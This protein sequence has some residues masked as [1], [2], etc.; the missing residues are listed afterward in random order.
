MCL[1]EEI[2]PPFA[3]IKERAEHRKIVYGDIVRRGEDW[4]RKGLDARV[5][6]EGM[7]EAVLSQIYNP[8]SPR[9]IFAFCD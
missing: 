5:I 2:V 7:L 9:D 8:R 1:S 6:S 4:R 3:G